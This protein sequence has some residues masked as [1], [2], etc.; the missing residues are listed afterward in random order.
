M[1]QVR[2]LLV[3]TDR[4]DIEHIRTFCAEAAPKVVFTVVRSGDECWLLL[5]TPDAPPFD[6]LV[7]D[8]HLPDTDGLTLLREVVDSGYP[9][10]VIIITVRRDVETAV[11]AMKMGAFDYLVKSGTYWEHLPRVIDSALARY[12]LTR[13]NQRLQGRLAAY[14]TEL[15]QAMYQ[16][17]LEKTRL[18]AVLEQLPE[19]VLIV[20]GT[21]GHTVAANH[22][23]ERLWGHPFVPNVC[24]PQYRHT[25]VA[26]LHETPLN[27]EERAIVQ[28]LQDGQPVL[29]MQ[30]ELTRP[31][32]DTIT[33]LVNAAPL[34][35]RQGSVGGAMAVFQ[36]ITEIKRLEHLKDEILSI[37]S[38]ELKNPLTIITGYSV[39]LSR[40]PLVQRDERAHRYAH[41]IQHQSERMYRLVA[42]LLD[43]SRLDLGQMALEQTSVDLV[44]LLSSVVEQQTITPHHTIRL[45]LDVPS[46]Q[47]EGDYTRLEQVMVNLVSNAIKYSPDGGDVVVS[48][49]R[50]DTEIDLS[51]AVCGSRV[52]APPPYALICVGDQGIGIAPE[53]QQPLFNRFYRA[54]EAARLAAG[55]GLGLYICAEIVRM[56]GGALCVES[57]AGK[58]ST[59]S[60]VLPLVLTDSAPPRSPP[61]AV[62]HR[63]PEPPRAAPRGKGSGE[64]GGFPDTGA[65][66]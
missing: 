41:I 7:I 65:G 35:T 49:L 30:G 54:K 14:A 25:G 52:T 58:G 55:Q 33:I 23:A 29:G 26:H 20:E 28:V 51:Q 8:S 37:A 18:Q 56:H 19:G 48:L 1:Q 12:H 47:V 50:Q 46:L 42:R 59:F 3:D 45:H 5:A 9:A 34:L 39:L 16:A 2:V 10:P 38:H 32:G 22:A 6:A 15:Q 17:Q 57:A 62:V 31:Q 61:A 36:D 60:V 4:H 24:I 13:E 63:Q 11:T 64:P 44:V 21:E 53:M 66:E 27:P 43:L 40:M